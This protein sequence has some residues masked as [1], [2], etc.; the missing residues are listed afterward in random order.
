MTKSSIRKVILTFVNIVSIT[1]VVFY[2]SAGHHHKSSHSKLL[3]VFLSLFPQSCST[4]SHTLA[5]VQALTK[6]S[7]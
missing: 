3:T 5:K 4:V 6:V 7:D 1:K 2:Y